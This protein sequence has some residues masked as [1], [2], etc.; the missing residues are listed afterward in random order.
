VAQVRVELGVANEEIARRR[1]VEEELRLSRDELAKA[2]A[3]MERMIEHAN[4]M[5][6]QAEA[7]NVAKSEFLA[8]M[9]HEIRTPMNA[10]IGFSELLV[11]GLPEGPQQSQAE[12]IRKSGQRCCG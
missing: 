10:I 12:V 8:N 6:R 3:E 7:A 1:Q 11:S 2:N 9:S 5:A 4:Q